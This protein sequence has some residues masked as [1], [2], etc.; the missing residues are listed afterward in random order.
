MMGVLW[1]FP[2]LL[3]TVKT[4]PHMEFPLLKTQKGTKEIEF[5]WFMGFSE[6]V[7]QVVLGMDIV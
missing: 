2:T 6:D 1:G 4:P 7:G 5:C 3:L